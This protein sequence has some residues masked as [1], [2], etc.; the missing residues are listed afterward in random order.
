MHRMFSVFG[1]NQRPAPMVTQKLRKRW[2]RPEFAPVLTENP[3]FQATFKNPLLYGQKF[4]RFCPMD[5]APGEPHIWNFIVRR[6]LLGS[7]L[8]ISIFTN[9]EA[10]HAAPKYSLILCCNCIQYLV[11]WHLKNTFGRFCNLLIFFVCCQHSATP[12]HPVFPNLHRRHPN[13]CGS[14]FARFDAVSKKVTKFM[15]KQKLRN[16]INYFY[17]MCFGISTKLPRNFVFWGKFL[18]NFYPRNFH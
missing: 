10:Q 9:M 16:F 17:I 4:S 18:V 13:C 3:V 6:K 8:S 2:H 1:W 5:S 11:E 12:S 14:N 15:S 7:S